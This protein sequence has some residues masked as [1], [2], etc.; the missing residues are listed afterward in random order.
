MAQVLL[1][2]G[3]RKRKSYRRRYGKQATS[4]KIIIRLLVLTAIPTSKIMCASGYIFNCWASSLPGCLNRHTR[5]PTECL[6]TENTLY[7]S[8]DLSIQAQRY[9]YIFPTFAADLFQ[10]YTAGWT[11]PWVGRVFVSGVAKQKKTQSAGP[12]DSHDYP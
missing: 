2:L 6:S 8:L 3:A 11:I 9:L 1:D 12:W 4:A 5:R 7:P 10:L